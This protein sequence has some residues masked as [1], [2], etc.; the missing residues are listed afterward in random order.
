LNLQLQR[1]GSKILQRATNSIARFRI[2]MMISHLKNALACYSAGVVVVNLEVVGLA[3]G[4]N[5]TN[6]EYT[7]S[8]AQRQRLRRLEI[9]FTEKE[10]IFVFKTHRATRGVVKNYSTGDWCCNSRL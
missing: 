10:N 7:Y 1:Q 3:T 4:A 8:Y 5:P 2:K 9:F 6:F